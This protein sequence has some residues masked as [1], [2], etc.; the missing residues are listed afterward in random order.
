M[1]LYRVSKGVIQVLSVVRE[2]KTGWRRD[3]GG[4]INR[5]Y[6][7][8]KYPRLSGYYYTT[9]INVACRWAKIQAQM[10]SDLLQVAQAARDDILTWHDDGANEDHLPT[11]RD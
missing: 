4:F 5:S 9:D 7:S 1:I 6:L 10:M 8:E 2:T 11:P 3:D